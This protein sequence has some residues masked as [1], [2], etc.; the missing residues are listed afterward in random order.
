ML[1]F[2]EHALFQFVAGTLDDGM[3]WCTF[4]KRDSAYIIIIIFILY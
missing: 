4:N 2:K 3:W 1:S